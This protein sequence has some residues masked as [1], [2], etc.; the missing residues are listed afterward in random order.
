MCEEDTLSQQLPWKKNNEWISIQSN[1]TPPPPPRVIRLSDL[2][3]CV[4][5]KAKMD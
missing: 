2:A 1:I 4:E 5:V 3:H